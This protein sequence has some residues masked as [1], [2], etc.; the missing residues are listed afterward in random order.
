MLVLDA[1]AIMAWVM[2]DETGL[3]LKRLIARGDPLIAP[4]PMWVDLRN[5]LIVSERRGHYALQRRDRDD[6]EV[7]T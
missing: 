5:I 4:F 3:D 2:P 7:A 1:S 6:I